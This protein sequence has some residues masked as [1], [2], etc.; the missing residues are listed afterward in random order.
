[1]AGAAPKPPAAGAEPKPPL[2]P[3]GAAGAGVPKVDVAG[4]PKGVE[5]GGE[6]KGLVFCCPNMLV[7]TLLC[8]IMR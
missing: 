7:M 1:V 5:A 3:K 2:E 4:A 6:A 8:T